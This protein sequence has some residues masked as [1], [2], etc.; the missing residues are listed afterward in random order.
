MTPCIICAQPTQTCT[1]PP[2]HSNVVWMC[3]EDMAR[4][5][6]GEIHLPPEDPTVFDRAESQRGKI[7]GMAEVQRAADPAWKF[8]A[9]CALHECSR[10][11]REFTADMVYRYIPNTVS[12]H[13]LKAMGPVMRLG[14]KLGWIQKTEKYGYTDRIK[15]HRGILHV[16]DS[17]VFGDPPLDHEP[18]M[19][20]DEMDGGSWYE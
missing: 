20:D 11:I 19:D 6:R 15:G 12:T 10:H 14:A 1:I 8:A 9:I 4:L 5:F 17:L 18:P 13:N 2:G 16:W 7:W 3:A